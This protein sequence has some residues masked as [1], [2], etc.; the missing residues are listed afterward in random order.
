MFFIISL[1]KY[2]PLIDMQAKQERHASIKEELL[3][4][5]GCKASCTIGS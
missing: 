5:Y 1:R 3:Q 4:L 2:K